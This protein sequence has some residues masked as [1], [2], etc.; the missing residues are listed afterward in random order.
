MSPTDLEELHGEHFKLKLPTGSASTSDAS[1]IRV[2]H[3]D[4]NEYC[5]PMA[6]CQTWFVGE[7]TSAIQFYVPKN[8]DTMIL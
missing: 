8:T 4:G 1:Q 7:P 2:I 5:L 3:V 6:S